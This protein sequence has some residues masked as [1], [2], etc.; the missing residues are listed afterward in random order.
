[1]ETV[2]PAL[3]DTVLKPSLF[4]LPLLPFLPC[5]FWT[6][7]FLWHSGL[8]LPPSGQGS[9]QQDSDP[10]QTPSVLH[11]MGIPQRE[12]YSYIHTAPR[13]KHLPQGGSTP[14]CSQQHHRPAFPPYTCSYCLICIFD[15]I[16]ISASSRLSQQPPPT[17]WHNWEFGG[18]TSSSAQLRTLL[19][20]SPRRSAQQMQAYDW[21][22]PW[23]PPSP[24][25]YPFPQVTFFILTGSKF[26]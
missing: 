1:M 20:Y 21:K 14:P 6:W 23:H 9:A 25:G 17:T 16:C 4:S 26:L 15:T 11:T 22:L 13:S 5:L 10:S 2:L 24:K 8:F 7:N 3:R 18:A 12:Q 19:A